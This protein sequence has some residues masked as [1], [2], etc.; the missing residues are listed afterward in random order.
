[1]ISNF[2]ADEDILGISELINSDEAI[3]STSLSEYL[4]I[5]FVDAD[6]DGQVDDTKIVIDSNGQAEGGDL[7]TIFIQDEQLVQSDLDQDN[8]DYD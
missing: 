5:T 1:M 2:D 6:N 8:V 7:T 4:E 3:D